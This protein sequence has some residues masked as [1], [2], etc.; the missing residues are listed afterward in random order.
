[1]TVEGKGGTSAIYLSV[2]ITKLRTRTVERAK[3]GLPA[4]RPS[5]DAC[6]WQLSVRFVKV[7]LRRLPDKS[8]G[9]QLPNSVPMGELL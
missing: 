7:Q 6:D 2:V 1:V 4:C 9:V 8:R 3:G 5:K